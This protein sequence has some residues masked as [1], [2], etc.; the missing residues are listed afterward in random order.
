MTATASRRL[1]AD[2]WK[3]WTGQTVSNLGSSVTQFALPLLVFQLTGSALNLGLTM[4][5]GMLPNLLFGLFIGAWV[6]RVDRKRLM[7]AVDILQA[8]FVTSVPVLAALG[9]LQLWWIYVVVFCSGL[10]NN[11]FQAAEFAAIPSL[12]P[13]DDLVTANGRIQASYSAA[14]VAGPLIAGVLAA[15]TPAYNLL[16]IDIASFFISATLLSRIR[17]SFNTREARRAT[18]IVADVGEGLRY[19]WGHPVLRNISIMMC[20]V[21]FVGATVYAQLVLFV[22]ERYAASEAQVGLFFSAGSLGVVVI[23][24]AAGLLRRRF[25]FSSVALGSL[26]I[27]GVLTVAMALNGL[28]WVGL[29]LWSVHM[30]F[31]ILFNINTSSLRQ[32]IVPGH[33][34]GRV[35][36]V[37]MVLG[38]SAVPLGALAGGW[39]IERTGEVTLIYAAIGVIT[40]LIPL[41][42]LLTPLGHAERYIPAA[43]ADGQSL[44]VKAPQDDHAVAGA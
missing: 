28:Y 8:V 35:I 4:V 40:T 23:S 34:L 5:F 20:L 29:I 41:V 32:A 30:G 11:C 33:M 27:T 43:A 1:N 37:A 44:S 7:I 25:S 26:M 16:W 17:V 21:N 22:T 3:F 36:S 31:A 18:S 19:V 2:F 14:M 24:L 6:D 12:V 42:F 10:L 13:T 15:F 9:M 38:Q 39:L